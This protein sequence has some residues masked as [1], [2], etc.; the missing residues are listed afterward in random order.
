MKLFP[1]VRIGLVFLV[2]LAALFSQAQEPAA[3]GNFDG[4]AELPRVYMKSSVADTPA[5]GKVIR[6]E[7]D[8]N[9]Q[10]A[11]DTAACGD[12][13]ELPAGASFAGHFR[14]T[15]KE[16]D[17]AHWIIVRTADAD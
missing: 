17:D 2:S 8:G 14:I 4:P 12:T 1:S 3:Q 11:F 15:K 7:E 9:L 13:I 10:H 6:V 5:P 16:C